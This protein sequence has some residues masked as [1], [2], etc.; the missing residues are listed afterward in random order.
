MAFL[1]VPFLGPLVVIVLELLVGILQAFVF[2]L[3]VM[4]YFRLAEESH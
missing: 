4:V 2:A 1:K 3:L